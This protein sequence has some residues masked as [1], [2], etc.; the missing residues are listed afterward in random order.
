[1]EIIFYTFEKRPNSTKQPMPS[2]GIIMPCTL[3]DEVSF[4]NPVIRVDTKSLVSGE[5]SPALY[6]YAQIPY[7]QRFYYITDWQYLNGCWECSLSVDVLASFKYEIGDTDSYIIRSATDYNGDIADAFYPV[8]TKTSIQKIQISSE[9]Y[10]TSLPSGCYV[11]GIINNAGNETRV[12]AVTYYALTANQMKAFMNYI[13]SNQL[14]DQMNIYEIGEGLWKS[15]FNPMQYIVSCVWFPF[16]ANTFGTETAN[17]KI[18]YWNST[19]SGTVVRYIVTDPVGFKST[20]PIPL[21]PQSNRGNY[22]NFAPYTR[23]T[24]YYPPFGEI[25]VDTSFMQYG[26]N[27]YLWGTMHIDYINGLANCYFAITNGYDRASA[28]PEKYFTMRSS[29]IGVPIQLSQVMKDYIGTLQGEASAVASF[30]TGNI[31]GVFSGIADGLKASMPKV[32]SNGANGSF[33]EI[34]EPPYLIVEHRRIVDE[35]RSE[36]GRPLCS[37]RKINTLSGYVKC[38]EADHKFMGTKQEN[39][40]INTYLQSGFFYE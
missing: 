36:F 18:G 5:F 19:A 16:P 10:H 12:G 14:H 21:H 3:K 8:T 6:N 30:A 38:G 35:N 40:Q 23:A 31:A 37:T 26:D 15:L 4:M 9:I 17:V 32:S 11:I 28:D 24:A 27:N 29:Q 13:F 22:L 39:E 1:M 33:I 34:V 2:E 20:L 25:P 7:W